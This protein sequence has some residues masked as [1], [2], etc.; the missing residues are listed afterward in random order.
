MRFL[1]QFRGVTKPCFSSMFRDTSN[2]QKFSMPYSQ[3]VQDVK[4]W[5]ESFSKHP[6]KYILPCVK[7]P[8]Q[9]EYNAHQFL[10]HYDKETVVT[11]SKSLKNFLESRRVMTSTTDAVISIGTG[12]KNEVKRTKSKQRQLVKLVDVQKHSLGD[13]FNISESPDSETHSLQKDSKK[14]YTRGPIKDYNWKQVVY[15]EYN[16]AAFL[17]GRSFACYATILRVLSEID[18]RTNFVPTSILDFGSGTGTSIWAANTLW[19]S[20]L[21][22]YVC[23]DSSKHMNALS[24][25]IFTGGKPDIELPGLFTRQFLP[26]SF[27]M[28]YDIVVSSYTL[29]EIS[30]TN[31]RLAL[32][33][34]LWKKVN[35]FLVLVEHGNFHGYYI[36]MEA[37]NLLANNM[38][39]LNKP[40]PCSKPLEKGHIFAP[41]PHKM[42]CPKFETKSACVFHQK[43]F[44]PS[45]Y[46][47]P[48]TSA[49]ASFTY[50]VMEKDSE[51][52][53]INTWPRV[54]GAPNRQ[55]TNCMHCH[56]CTPKGRI[57]HVGITK[58]LSSH[59]Y[60]VAKKSNIGDHLPLFHIDDNS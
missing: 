53:S 7:V 8:E 28:T 14:L 24:Q 41:C 57:E 2:H 42:E 46:R 35:R 27:N 31:D 48:R 13:G 3:S 54:I 38:E 29:S 52:V 49:S 15:D 36:I 17:L 43:Y 32:L 33:K 60:Q 59:L 55:G 44:T 12:F 34:I 4:W 47:T 9:F 11:V 5:P 39:S 1:I 16:S 18:K 22:Q 50:L 10:K 26:V 23:V 25:H 6:G 21:K 58:S 56:L 40:K 37:R 30:N 51:E 20:S 19:Q 45:F